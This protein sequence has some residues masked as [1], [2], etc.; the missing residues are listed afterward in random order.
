[1]SPGPIIS[2]SADDEEVLQQFAQYLAEKTPKLA[3]ASVICY[4]EDVRGFAA[5]LRARNIPAAIGLADSCEAN[6]DE[7]FATL[8]KSQLKRDTIR[9]RAGALR[10]FFE[11]LPQR[12]SG[13][14][15][16]Q[17][18]LKPSIALSLGKTTGDRLFALRNSSNPIHRAVYEFLRDQCT[19]ASPHTINAYTGDLLKFLVF[20]EGESEL[21][22]IDQER[23]T[24]FVSQ[25]QHHGLSNSSVARALGGM[26]SFCAWL[27]GK[28][29]I[30]INPTVGVSIS[31]AQHRPLV[32][33]HEE[34]RSALQAQCSCVF[35]ER[36]RLIW[37]L[38]YSCGITTCELVSID[39]EHIDWLRK[40]IL[41]RGKHRRERYAGLSDRCVSALRAYLPARAQLIEHSSGANSPLIINLRGDRISSRSIGRIVKALATASGLSSDVHP[42]TLRH[43]FRV[44]KLAQGANI[45]AVRHALGVTGHS[46]AAGWRFR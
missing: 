39:I 14:T 20:L 33:E 18:P 12:P 11:Y 19:S 30:S 1:M 6:A 36:D 23:I 2:T 29:R 9:R 26:K 31:R 5:F 35:P 24:G 21:N 10:H 32:P 7:Y 22:Q 44:H 4:E 41:I 27:K 15:T 8:Q 42:H 37:E 3:L 17:T 28:R 13:S 38:L 46:P 40:R 25:L 45:H 16:A 43:A 34:M